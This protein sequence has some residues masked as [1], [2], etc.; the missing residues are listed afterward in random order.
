MCVTLM[1]VHALSRG[2]GVVQISIIIYY[3]THLESSHVLS[4]VPLLLSLLMAQ[5]GHDLH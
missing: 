2:V 3:Y 1:F 4:N 5:T